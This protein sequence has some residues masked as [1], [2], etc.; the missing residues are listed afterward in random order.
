[1]MKEHPSL[2]IKDGEIK[3]KQ[4]VYYD[5]EK[6]GEIARTHN[7]KF[8]NLFKNTKKEFMLELEKNFPKENH[9]ELH[10]EIDTYFESMINFRMIVNETAIDPE[11][12][13]KRRNAVKKD[14]DKRVQAIKKGHQAYNNYTYTIEDYGDHK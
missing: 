8:H 13:K 2:F 4:L 5:I 3:L 10:N 7:V 11:L 12:N 9:E 1:M 14:H 6:F